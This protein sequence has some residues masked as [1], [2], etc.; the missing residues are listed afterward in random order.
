MSSTLKQ[1]NIAH[2]VL[3]AKFHEQEAQIIARAGQYGSVVVAT[4]MAGRG[5]D[6]KLEAGLNDKLATNYALW[7]EKMISGNNIDK[8]KYTVNATLYSQAEFDLTIDALLASF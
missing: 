8:K 1:Q 6:I 5:T 3:N 2:S 7:I 4:N